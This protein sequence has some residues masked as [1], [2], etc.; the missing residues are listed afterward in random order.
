MTTI[1]TSDPAEAAEH[2]RRGLPVAFPTETV[3]GLGAPVSDVAGIRRIYEAKERPPTNPLI[4]HVADQGDISNIAA[5]VSITAQLLIEAFFPGPLTL[6]LPKH[7][8][9]P[10]VVSAGLSTVG[11][12]MP[13]HPIALRFIE[14]VGEAVAAPSANRSGRPSPTSWAAVKD[15]LDGRIACILK[16]DR[17]R[18]GL[19]S[20]VLD[21]TGDEAVILRP[22]SVTLEMLRSVVPDVRLSHGGEEIKQRSPG[23][24]FRHY[25]PRADVVIV[26]SPPA[27]PGLNSAF[28]G[29][30]APADTR[31][32]AYILVCDSVADY[33]R[34]LFNFFRE[35]EGLGV[36]RI[37]CQAVARDGIGLALMDR[38]DRAAAR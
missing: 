9:V 21:C 8:S 38:I 11:V 12:R 1:I 29:M 30:S 25:A 3:Y 16:G 34:D 6:V 22:G 18:M 4:V 5:E 27:A 26:D 36:E 23:T 15:D 7:Q 33:A 32:Y 10:D 17:T 2:A 19:E 24:R 14:V 13:D 28:I 31:P 35:C 20:T 37:F